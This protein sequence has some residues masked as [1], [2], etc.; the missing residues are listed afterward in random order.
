MNGNSILLDTNTVLYFLSGDETISDFIKEKKIFIS[1]IT[2]M[3]LLS[4]SKI[5]SKELKIISGF[6]S[7]ITVININ[8]DIKETAIKIRRSS[9]LKLPDSIIAASSIFLQIPLI[10]ADKEIK[11]AEG[12]N[13]I[14]YEK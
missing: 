6:I 13:I 3:E 9:K 4:Y 5:T 10:T 12:L 11:N 8:N 14:Y 2:E 1:I 7:E